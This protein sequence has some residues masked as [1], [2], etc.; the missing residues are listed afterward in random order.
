[1]YVIFFT[2]GSTTVYGRRLYKVTLA[3]SIG[4]WQY[5]QVSCQLF[6]IEGA[7]CPRTYLVYTMRPADNATAGRWAGVGLVN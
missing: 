5:R 7:T 3:P 2:L 1:M 6:N 4:I